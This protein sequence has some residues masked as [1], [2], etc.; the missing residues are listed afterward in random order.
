MMMMT[1][2]NDLP[3]SVQDNKIKLFA[4]DTNV[5]VFAK[6]IVSLESKTNDCVSRMEKW[7][8]S[9]LLSVNSSKTCYSLF[10][11]KK[12]SVN[13]DINIK[14]NN[15]SIVKINS[16]V[17]LGIHID[18][19]LKWYIHVDSI[20]NGLGKYT[21]IFFKLGFILLSDVL[22]N[23]YFSIVH[24]RLL[25]GIEIYGNADLCVIDKVIKLNNR[26]LR[27]LQGKPMDYPVYRL[28]MN[29]DTLP[30]PVLYKFKVLKFMFMFN[31]HKS[32]LPSVFHDYFHTNSFVHSWSMS[33][34]HTELPATQVF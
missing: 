25:Y 23:M 3:N 31:H 22:K 32:L 7:F 17:Y 6:D 18:D 27:T 5:F 34:I 21:S 20:Y 30:I 1:M 4:D 11:C 9:N 2:I 26:L 10:N 13:H 28:Y 12:A 19:R 15:S 16:C 33:H 24:S 8:L 14:L 29:Y